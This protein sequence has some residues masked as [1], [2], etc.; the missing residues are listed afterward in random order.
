MAADTS[1]FRSSSEVAISFSL[2]NELVSSD[3][4]GGSFV[5]CCCCK[6]RNDLAAG[7]SL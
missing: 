5:A 6:E 3:C 7:E 2:D 4:C 1:T